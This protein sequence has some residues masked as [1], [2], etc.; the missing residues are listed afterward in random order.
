MNTKLLYLWPT[1]NF[2]TSLSTDPRHMTVEQS[3]AVF[4]VD[5]GEQITN[6]AWII[7]GEYTDCTRQYRNTVRVEWKLLAGRRQRYEGNVNRSLVESLWNYNSRN[8]KSGRY[9]R[10]QRVAGATRA[11]VYAYPNISPGTN[12]LSVSSFIYRKLWRYCHVNIYVGSTRNSSHSY[13]P[14]TIRT[15]KSRRIGSSPMEP[16]R[17]PLF[18]TRRSSFRDFP[19]KVRETWNTALLSKHWANSNV[20]WSS[21]TDCKFIA[22]FPKERRPSISRYLKYYGL[23]V[24]YNTRKGHVNPSILERCDSGMVTIWSIDRLFG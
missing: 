16:R 6:R 18:E 8:V 9:A 12:R 13:F 1:V 14:W 3:F 21:A 11:I 23:W 5:P 20:A 19:R 22:H 24:R 15:R 4:R 7:N 17:V 2:H 10:F